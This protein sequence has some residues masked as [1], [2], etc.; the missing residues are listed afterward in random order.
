MLGG[1]DGAGAHEDRA[2]AAMDGLDVLDDGRPPRLRGG[3]YMV[4]PASPDEAPVRRHTNDGEPVDRPELTADLTSGSRHAGEP[5][6]PPEESLVAHPRPR[7]LPA[8]ERT[9]FLGL[10]ELVQAV[11][12]GAVGHDAP[13]V[14]VDDLHFPVGHEVVPVAV[15]EMLGD[16][17]LAHELFA[18][19]ASRE[20]AAERAGKIFE[21]HLSC[22][23]DAD[24]PVA[25]IDDEVGAGAELSRERQGGLVQPSLRRLVDSPRDDERRARLVHQHAVGLI[26]EAVGEPAQQKLPRA[27][28]LARE[29]LELQL[30]AARIAPEDETIPEI[31]ED[32]LLVR[33]I[34]DVARVRCA[35]RLGV[36]AVR[37]R[38]DGEPQRPVDRSHPVCVAL[39]EIIV[40]GDDVHRHSGQRHRAG[41]QGSRQRLA[42]AG[43]HL[44]DDTGQE[45]PATDELNVEVPQA[46]RLGGRF[47][48]HRKGPGHEVFAE[49]FTMK[50]RPKIVGR[51]LEP[52]A[53]GAGEGGALAGDERHDPCPPTVASADPPDHR[54][55]RRT[56]GL[57]QPHAPWL[58]SLGVCAARDRETEDGARH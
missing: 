48:D 29:A 36:H 50:R 45:D 30:D 3:I 12:P 10:E 46:Q 40:D 20:H 34:G 44:G 51:F 24:G 58:D 7:R 25:A 55:H 26:D 39:D 57:V 28:L 15:E 23:G 8:R 47:S 2:A 27:C 22:I 31:V 9:T 19:L 33:A 1:L 49:A 21:A 4:G 38:S 11:L 52:T 5:D 42:F 13:R 6:V 18:S 43:L 41:R 56:G 32:D 54:S 17:R 14:F 37:D 35:P 16:E 53:A